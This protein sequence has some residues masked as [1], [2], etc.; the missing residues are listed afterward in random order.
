MPDP[1][2]IMAI[3]G[4]V[5]VWKKLF[6]VE[7][8]KKELWLLLAFIAVKLLIQLVPADYGY[9][10]DEL[11][12]LAMSDRLDWGFVDVPPITPFLMFIWKTL[13][14]AS[15]FSLKVLPALTGVAVIT[16]AWLIVKRMN[17]GFLAQ[18]VTLVCVTFA[19]VYIGLDSI[20]TYDPFDKLCWVLLLFWVFMLIETQNE[21]WLIGTGIVSG[22]ALMTKITILYPLFGLMTAFLFTKER[23]YYR[24]KR[25]WLAGGLALIIFSPYILWQIKHHFVS[26]EYYSNYT[27]KL[28][29]LNPLE[30]LINQLMIL[31]PLTAIF[32]LAGLYYFLFDREG[33]K[34]RVFGIAFL[35]ITLLS[36]ILGTRMTLTTPFYVILFAG[37]GRL[38]EKICQFKGWKG[39][40]YVYTCLAC[41]FGIFAVPLAKPM[42]PEAFY[43]RY[44]SAMGQRT[45]KEMEKHPQ[46]VL[47]Q[48]YADRH[49]W[50]ELAANAKKTFDMLNETEKRQACFFAFNYG[51]AA[52]INFF[53][54]P[55][56]LPE[57]VSGRNQYYVWGPRGFSGEVVIV[58]GTRDKGKLERYFGEVTQGAFH[59]ADY[60]MPYE[61]GLYFYI[62]R[63]PKFKSFKEIWNALHYLG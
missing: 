18:W 39:L 15:L 2:M 40:A 1:K 53:G 38:A 17:G 47:P 7:I 29:E 24:S 55:L 19:I 6:G 12:C 26:V 41:L 30:Y 51:E 57:A 33:R 59:E 42:I 60:A 13:F 58:F 36:M 50:P 9:F 11:Y 37:G 34:Y 20:F 5:T 10:R 61:T 52:A 25:F 31:S 62:C 56:G 43:S 28:S 35:V 32:S 22:L 14:G 8:L 16:V 27:S 48:F 46:G 44:A 49:G 63:K 23:R 3:C 54:K 4:V 45:V 21:R